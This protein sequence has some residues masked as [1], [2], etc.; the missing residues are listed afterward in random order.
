MK[1]YLTENNKCFRD[2]REARLQIGVPKEVDVADDPNAAS[3]YV[4]VGRNDDTHV[5]LSYQLA[6]AALTPESG[7][8]S[9]HMMEI[10]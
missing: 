9:V 10:E 2:E 7:C 1:L 6:C 8:K 5:T 3:V 4:V